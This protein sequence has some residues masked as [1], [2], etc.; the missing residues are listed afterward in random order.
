MCQIFAN[1]PLE[2]YSYITRSIRI[3]GHSTSI[4]LEASF[5]DILDQIAH[6]QNMTTP[7]FI[8]YI[9]NEA[10]HYNGKISNFA[11]LLRCACLLYLKR[12]D[13]V[14]EIVKQQLMEANHNN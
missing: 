1:Q 3:S 7:S 13:D 10:L 11:S 9:Y 14:M 2:S 8:T 6:Q 12:P 5:W 4:K